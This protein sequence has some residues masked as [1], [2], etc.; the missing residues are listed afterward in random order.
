MNTLKNK[1]GFG[2]WEIPIAVVL[3][4]LLL[5]LSIPKFNSLI[6]QSKEAQTKYS[7][8]RM[9]NA[10]TAYYGEHQSQ[11]PQGDVAKALVPN[12]IEKIPQVV[13]PGAEP[14]SEVYTTQTIKGNEGRG[15]WYYVDDPSYSTYGVLR[16]N[17]DTPTYAGENWQDL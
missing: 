10:I 17:I 4:I 5:G 1:K 9:R 15:G 13:A 16:V 8:T 7:L 3:I 11:Y 2:A 14:S 12:Y 6:R